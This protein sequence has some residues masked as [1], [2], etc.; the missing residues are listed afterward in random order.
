MIF[1]LSQ[2]ERTTELTSR[3]KEIMADGFRRRD[4][5]R[6]FVYAAEVRAPGE[7][8]AVIVPAESRENPECLKR[9]FREVCNPQHNKIMERHKFHSRNQKQGENSVWHQN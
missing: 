6:S 9:K 7:D 4:E 1:I 5:E 3:L 8:G 2:A